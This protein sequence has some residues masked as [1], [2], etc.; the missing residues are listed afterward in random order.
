MRRAFI[1]PL[2]QMPGRLIVMPAIDGSARDLFSRWRYRWLGA[3]SRIRSLGAFGLVLI[4]PQSDTLFGF[5]P[6]CI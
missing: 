2:V 6:S 1:R 3:E 5:R 4:T